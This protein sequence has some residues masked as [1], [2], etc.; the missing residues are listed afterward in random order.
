[1]KWTPCVK[2]DMLIWENIEWIPIISAFINNGVVN[3][4]CKA[5]F[6]I[7]VCESKSFNDV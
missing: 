2:T 1:M 3:I 5:S 7:K 4:K 6:E